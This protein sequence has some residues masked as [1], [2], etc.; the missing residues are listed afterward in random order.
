MDPTLLKWLLRVEE[1]EALCTSRVA[2]L[3]DQSRTNAQKRASTEAH[4]RAHSQLVHAKNLVLE[5]LAQKRVQISSMESQLQAM[6]RNEERS[7]SDR[8]NNPDS[9]V[10]TSQRRVVNLRKHLDHALAERSRCQAQNKRMCDVVQPHQ[11]RTIVLQDKIS[12]AT[13]RAEAHLRNK[14]SSLQDI[15]RRSVK[16]AGK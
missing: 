7:K 3:N 9:A 5:K 6:R 14:K 4:Q 13:A 11:Q 12:K 16:D 8:D 2:A 1:T 15:L 10:T